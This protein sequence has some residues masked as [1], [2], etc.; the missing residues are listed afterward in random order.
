MTG[1]AG[2]GEGYKPA[3]GKILRRGRAVAVLKDVEEEAEEGSDPKGDSS[4]V[5]YRPHGKQ[6]SAAAQE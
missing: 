3:A 4:N 2:A 6:C 5:H 1:A